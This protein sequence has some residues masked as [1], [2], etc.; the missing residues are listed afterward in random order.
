MRK[1]GNMFRISDCPND[2][3]TNRE[4]TID[5]R[6][7]YGNTAAH[8]EG[9]FLTPPRVSASIKFGDLTLLLAQ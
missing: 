9:L 1:Y 4:R 6:L 8:A 5:I 3:L 2:A 7:L